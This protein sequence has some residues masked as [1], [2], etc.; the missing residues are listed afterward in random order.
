MTRSLVSQLVSQLNSQSVKYALFLELLFD[1]GP[2][3]FHQ[4]VGT[5]NAT[6]AGGSARDWFG[7]GDLGTVDVI[8]E[9]VD[10]KSQE[11]QFMLSGLDT[12]LT[13][14]A[15]NNYCGGRV[16]K[17]F[18]GAFDEADKLTGNLSFL[19]RGRMNGMQV[20]F[21]SASNTITIKAESEAATLLRSRFGYFSHDLQQRRF[22][23]DLGFEFLAQLPFQKVQWAGKSVGNFNTYSS[24]AQRRGIR[25]MYIP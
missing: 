8:R 3:R 1:S 2:A 15:V 10:L 13:N 24:D 25:P 23:G 14:E 18:I 12:T 16:A 11:L 19:W 7:T 21:G 20:A 4:G 22:S 6:E 5:I 9:N 17:L